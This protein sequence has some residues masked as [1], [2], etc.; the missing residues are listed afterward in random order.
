MELRM[1]LPLLAFSFLLAW[2]SN[3]KWRLYYNFITMEQFTWHVLLNR[4]AS[5]LYP[6]IVYIY[7]YIYIYLWPIPPPPP[8]PLFA[9]TTLLTLNLLIS[10]VLVSTGLVNWLSGCWGWGEVIYMV[11]LW[12]AVPTIIPVH[13]PL[14]ALSQRVELTLSW[15]ELTLS[16]VELTLS[17]VELT[18]SWVGGAS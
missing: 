9:T 4:L 7:I 14:A 3:R 11:R 15:V 17:W 18:L 1:C 10:V 6:F 13:D 2:P 5:S 12:G 16:W 8:P